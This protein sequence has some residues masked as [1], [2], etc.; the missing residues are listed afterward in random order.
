[1]IFLSKSF[2]CCVRIS[3][4]KERDR[5][6]QILQSS[7]RN[8][9]HI[10][11]DKY[12]KYYEIDTRKKL[13]RNT[14]RF[15][16]TEQ[17]D[18]FKYLSD[19][20]PVET[21]QNYLVTFH[22]ISGLPWWGS[23]ILSTIMIRTLITLPLAVYQHYIMA[24]L[25]NLRL[26]MPAIVEEL[27]METAVAM[28][29]FHWTEE[30]AKLMFKHS[31]KKQWN[32]LIVR[33]NCHPFKSTLLLWI[34]IPMWVFIS[35]ALRNLTYMLPKQTIE[36]QITFNQL[37]LEGFLWMPNLTDFDHSLILPIALGIFNLAL[38]EIHVM[39]RT[40]PQSKLQKYITNFFRGLS[41]L[42][43]PVSA[44]VPSALCL[45]WTT[46]TLFGLCQNLLLIS[47][48]F[49]RLCRIPQTTSELNKPYEH[50]LVR[51]GERFSVFK[52]K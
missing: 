33:D 2:G 5:I 44:C 23:I 18:F 36:A 16:H 50:L 38:T 20:T 12:K 40:N 24:K 52:K 3:R 46:S 27:K 4:I 39:L 49:K 13:Y 17:N 11:T 31:L 37:S 7:I 48:K 45:Y 28:K 21:A 43:I 29:R 42:M 26:E 15:Q 14:S 22:D 30:Q 8:Y 19:S 9:S 35:I 6:P 25:Q 1:M 32:K 34:Q 10:F 47:P 51:I 41:I